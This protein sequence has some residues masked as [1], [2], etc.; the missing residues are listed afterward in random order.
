MSESSAA[1]LQFASADVE[2]S[3]AELG[4]ITASP[5]P[6]EQAVRPAQRPTAVTKILVWQTFSDQSS[7]DKCIAKVISSVLGVKLVSRERIG[8]K[9]RFYVVIDDAN[10]KTMEQVFDAERVICGRFAADEL[11]FEVLPGEE[12]ASV[13]PTKAVS[14]WRSA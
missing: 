2:A 13:I 7:F 5:S 12:L 6:E 1:I 14:L 4:S 11:E 8:E 9:L 3:L 10:P